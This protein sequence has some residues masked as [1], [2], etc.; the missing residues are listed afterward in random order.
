MLKDIKSD[1]LNVLL[2]HAL[3]FEETLQIFKSLFT[4]HT[5]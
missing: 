3:D 4:A 1:F 5:T 2:G